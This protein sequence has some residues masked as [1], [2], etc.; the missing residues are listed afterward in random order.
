MLKKNTAPY[1]ITLYTQ[2][3]TQN[4]IVDDSNEEGDVSKEWE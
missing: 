4:I 3:N 2:G 1:K